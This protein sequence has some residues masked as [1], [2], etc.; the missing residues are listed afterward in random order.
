MAQ[1]RATVL[2]TEGRLTLLA[3]E[4]VEMDGRRRDVVFTMV[5]ERYDTWQRASRERLASGTVPDLVD[6]MEEAVIVTAQ[7][8]RGDADGLS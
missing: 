4:L 6:L 8:E 7:D 3:N 5:A 1:A 2:T